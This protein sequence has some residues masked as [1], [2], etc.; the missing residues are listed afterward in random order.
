MTAVSVFVLGGLR[1]HSMPNQA[2]VL[3]TIAG[4]GTLSDLR[5]PD[6]SDCATVVK[7]FYEWRNYALAWSHE[8]KPTSQ[9]EAVIQILEAA[10]VKGLN[11]ADYDAGLWS[12]RVVALRR[13]WRHSS[14]HDLGRFDIA[15]TVSITRYIADLHMG[16]ANPR[17]LVSCLEMQQ[18]KCEIPLVLRSLM[19]PT[20]PNELLRTI[21]PT[22]PGY[23]RTLTALRIYRGLA[24]DD[25]GELLPSTEKPLEPGTKYA[26]VARLRQLLCRLG[27]LSA[28]LTAAS[29]GNV[30]E[31]AL[32]DAVERFQLRHGLEADG[33]IGRSTLTQLN[34]PL[35][36]RVRQLQ[37]TLERYRWLPH[38][39][40]QPLIVVNIP[41]FRLRGL[42]NSYKAE[43]EMKVVVG[44]AFRHQ[45]PIF[46]AV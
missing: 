44:R 7:D 45:T 29:T 20:N 40:D 1:T 25:D 32:V 39:L 4:A 27:D 21:E 5:W 17:S 43:I 46:S 15:L 28:D 41:E 12:D 24:D 42:N 35:W 33:R 19:N 30:Y 3:R 10:E 6:F 11:P 9:A 13:N 36:R 16:K 31:G 8:S 38:R 14:D 23:Y 22:F 18:Q 34:T 2:V 37:L 26:G